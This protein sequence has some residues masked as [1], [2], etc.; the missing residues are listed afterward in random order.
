MSDLNVN[1]PADALGRAKNCGITVLFGI[2]PRVVSITLRLS[3]SGEEVEWNVT[4]K[5]YAKSKY[6]R[7]AF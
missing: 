5:F 4:D 1:W 2:F 7:V 6:K 3:I